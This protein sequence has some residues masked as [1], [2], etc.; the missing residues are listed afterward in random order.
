[1]LMLTSLKSLTTVDVKGDGNCLP[2]A[3]CHDLHGAEEGHD[4]L[5]CKVADW[6]KTKVSYLAVWRISHLTMATLLRTCSL[7]ERC[8]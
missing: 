7:S 4:E 8:A 3:A 2:C 1:M 6:L 5:R